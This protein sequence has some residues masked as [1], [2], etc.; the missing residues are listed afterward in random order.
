MEYTPSQWEQLDIR[1]CDLIHKLVFYSLTA[2]EEKELE[3]LQRLFLK[4]KTT[5]LKP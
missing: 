4:V 2:A 3:K 1:R 5:C